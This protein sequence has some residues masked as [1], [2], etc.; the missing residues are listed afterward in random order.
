[1]KYLIDLDGTLMNGKVA[2]KDA[3][4][5]IQELQ[6]ENTDFLI[7]TNSIKSPKV[8]SERLEGVGIIIA[9]NQILNP[10]NAIN[11]YILKNIYSRALIIGSSTEIEQVNA[12]MDKYN[13]D[14]IVLLDFEKENITYNDLQYIFSFLQKDVDIIAASGS[15][16]YLKDGIRYLDTGAF[17]KLLESAA[18][19]RIKILGKP[20]IEYFNAG[21]SALKTNAYDVTVIGDDWN[22]DIVGA[23]NAGCNSVL[24][25]TGKYQAGDESKCKVQKVVNNLMELF[26]IE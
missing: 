12:K 19:T 7:M 14:I 17:V 2:Y 15:S 20:S 25:K 16:Y 11:L 1:M 24:I 4:L 23:T 8:I 21:I 5:F 9:P 26:P 22:T 3:V 18:N 10:I 6:R 13:P